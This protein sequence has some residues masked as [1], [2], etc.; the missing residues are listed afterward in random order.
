MREY[1]RTHVAW[2]ARN[3]AID[4]ARVYTSGLNPATLSRRAESS[5]A[6]K[7]AKGCAVRKESSLRDNARLHISVRRNA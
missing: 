4:P 3:P 6:T 7:K 1:S 5:Q 2:G